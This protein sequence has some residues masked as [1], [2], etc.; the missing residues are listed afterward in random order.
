MRRATLGVS[1]VVG[2]VMVGF[3]SAAAPGAA[4]VDVKPERGQATQVRDLP[5]RPPVPAAAV[6]TKLNELFT[7]YGTAPLTVDGD[8]G[9][10]TRQRVCAFRV[11]AGLPVSASPIVPGSAEEDL[12]MSTPTLPTPFTSAILSERW[13]LVD[14]TC[15]MMFIGS[16]TELVFVFPTSTGSTGFETRFQNRTPIYMYRSASHN[17]GWHDSSQYPVGPD[18][19]LNGNMYKPLYFDGGQAIHGANSVPYY[20]ASKGCTRLRVHDM[21]RLLSWLGLSDVTGTIVSTTALNTT[22]NVQGHWTW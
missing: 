16:G 19:P 18:N 13:V 17:N 7:P 11:A 1:L 9:R 15:Q 8:L 20:P 10:Y 5:P 6:Q 21:N 4:N 14:L 3:V 22:V 12:L 2:L